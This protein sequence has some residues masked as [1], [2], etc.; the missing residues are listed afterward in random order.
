[1]KLLLFSDLHCDRAAAR[2]LVRRA[3]T[4]DVL[5]GAGDFASM[6]RGL[7]ICL[8]MLL[9]TGKPFFLVPGNNESLEELRAACANYPHARVLHGGGETFEGVDFWGLGGGVPP[10]PFGEWSYDL[11]E[12]EA[13]DLLRDCPPGAILISH[14]P[15]QGAVDV[16]S[17]GLHLGSIAVRETIERAT[18]RLVVCGHVHNCAGQSAQ[19]GATEIVNVGPQGLWREV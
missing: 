14:S 19:I 1:M 6:R 10:T 13:R 16:S 3:A 18:P 15:P 7:E 17:R 2:S 11:I 8:P 5:V 12:E 9:E 4:A